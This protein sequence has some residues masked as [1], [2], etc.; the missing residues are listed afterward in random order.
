MNVRHDP[1]TGSTPAPGGNVF[2]AP[3]IRR[4]IERPPAHVVGTDRT[5]T[6]PRAVSS[7]KVRPGPGRATVAR[8]EVSAAG[9]RVL[10][11][12]NG[13]HVVWPIVQGA[14]AITFEDAGLTAAI[15]DVAR[16]AAG[17]D[18]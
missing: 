9:L 12:V 1:P 16:A 7:V 11:L 2:T 13:P 10:L 8:V 15:E 5:A 14:P 6:V 4:R 18:A 17:W 3:A